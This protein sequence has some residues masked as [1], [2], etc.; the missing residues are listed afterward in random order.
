MIYD[1]RLKYCTACS[2]RSARPLVSNVPRFLRFP[3]FGFFL[4]EYRRYS[5][6]FNF[7]IIAFLYTYYLAPHGDIGGWLRLG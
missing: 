1:L 7:L 3:V 4:R 2:C 6:D 5:P